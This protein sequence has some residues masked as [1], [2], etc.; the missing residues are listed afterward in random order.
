MNRENV[1][2]EVLKAANTSMD[3]IKALESVNT[4]E[5]FSVALLEQ[6]RAYQDLE[7]KVKNVITSEKISVKDEGF[8][9]KVMLWG[10][11]K[12]KTIVDSSPSKLAEMLIQGANMGVISLTKIENALEPGVDRSLLDELSAKYH[13]T[14][15]TMK[16]YL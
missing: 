3:S 11:T 7:I 9:P 5:Q 15:D 12:V 8:M 4:D 14:V 13:D 1:L 6:E 16:A 2:R 10:T